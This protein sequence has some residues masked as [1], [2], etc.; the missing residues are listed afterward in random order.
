MMMIIWWCWYHT[1]HAAAGSDSVPAAGAG[2]ARA[3]GEAVHGDH[4]VRGRD[5]RGRGDRGQREEEEGRDEPG[6][7]VQQLHLPH[8]R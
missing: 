4:R 7:G 2:R 1:I 6:A 3:A 8:P 5:T